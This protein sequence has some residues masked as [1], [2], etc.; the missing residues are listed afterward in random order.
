[1]SSKC[2]SMMLLVNDQRSVNFGDGTATCKDTKVVNTRFSVY[3]V[4][5]VPERAMARSNSIFRI[6]TMSL[7]PSSPLWAS[8]QMA[9]RPI[10]TCE[11]TKQVDSTAAGSKQW[12]MSPFWLPRPRLWG[13]PCPGWRHRRRRPRNDRPL[14]WRWQAERRSA[15]WKWKG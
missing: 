2:A 11:E 12:N 9:G 15:E 3:V 6:E 7:T 14:A 8:P 5:W 10:K 4:N 13:C 1:M